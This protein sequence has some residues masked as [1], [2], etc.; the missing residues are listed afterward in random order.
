MLRGREG[1]LVFLVLEERLEGRIKRLCGEGRFER[2]GGG[3]GRDLIDG[4]GEA[5][6]PGAN[7]IPVISRFVHD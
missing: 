3:D 6:D 5:R 1:R 4:E 7:R 2:E